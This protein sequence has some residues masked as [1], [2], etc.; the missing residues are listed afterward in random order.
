MLKQWLRFP[1]KLMLLSGNEQSF[2]AAIHRRIN[3]FQSPADNNVVI[4]SMC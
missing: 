4:Q 2:V 1:E 3:A